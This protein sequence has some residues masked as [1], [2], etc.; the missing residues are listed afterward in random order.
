MTSGRSSD[1]SFHCNRHGTIDTKKRKQVS[2]FAVILPL[3][4]AG[5]ETSGGCVCGSCVCSQLFHFALITLFI[6]FAANM[7]DHQE[8]NRPQGAQAPGQDDVSNATILA[9]L[10]LIQNDLT[11]VKSDQATNSKTLSDVL[12]TLGKM[13]TQIDGAATA[14]DLEVLQTTNDGMKTQLNDV[15]ETQLQMID[16]TAVSTGP[17]A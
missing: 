3:E 14:K 17:K 7:A 15:N 16:G 9:M 4:N 6:E 10:R 13:Q 5:T 11:A 2:T 8:G 1:Q 12:E